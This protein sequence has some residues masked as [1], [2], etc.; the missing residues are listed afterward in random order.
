MLQSM[1]HLRVLNL[2]ENKIEVI[3]DE[4][5]HLQGLVRLDLANNNIEE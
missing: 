5:T 4:M 2:R 1:G 3:P